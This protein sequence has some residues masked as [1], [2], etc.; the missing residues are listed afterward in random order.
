MCADTGDKIRSGLSDVA[1]INT[2]N[3]IAFRA[4][5]KAKAEELGLFIII[6]AHLAVFERGP[7]SFSNVSWNR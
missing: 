3:S 1:T 7:P 2:V 5:P 4:F 6:L